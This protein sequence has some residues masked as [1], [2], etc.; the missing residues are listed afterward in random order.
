VYVKT[1]IILQDLEGRED[2]YEVGAD[3]EYEPGGNG[4]SPSHEVG[5]PEFS[6]PGSTLKESRLALDPQA[7]E[8][9]PRG[10]SD[11]VEEA[12]IEA[13]ESRIADLYDD[14]V[15]GRADYEYDRMKEG[16]YDE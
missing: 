11:A 15:N 8:V 13:H 3:V 5:E 14:E 7:G 6:A 9:F 16:Y 10:W 4:W 12:L 1:Y 2:E